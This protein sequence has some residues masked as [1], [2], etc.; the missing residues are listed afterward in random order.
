M[1]E[2]KPWQPSKNIIIPDEIEKNILKNVNENILVV[3]GPGSGKTEMLAQK[4]NFLFETDLCKNPYKILALSYKV[5]AA[6]TLKDRVKKRCGDIANYRFDSYT[7]DAFLF[8]IVQRF[9]KL[10]PDWIEPLSSNMVMCSD[11]KNLKQDIISSDTDQ[12]ARINRYIKKKLMP[13]NLMRNMGYTIILHNQEVREIVSSP[14]QYIFIDEFQDTT[15]MHYNILELLFNKNNIRFMAVGDSKQSIMGFAG[16]L[17][18]IFEKYL[19]DYNAKEYP[20][21]YNYRSNSN[22]VY[23]MNEVIENLL[24]QYKKNKMIAYKKSDDKYS[25][26]QNGQ[27]E[28]Y[29][30]QF[31]SIANYISNKIQSNN[32]KQHDFV[33]VKRTRMLQDNINKINDIFTRYGLLIRNDMEKIYKDITIQNLLEYQLSRFLIHFFAY[34]EGSITPENYQELLSTYSTYKNYDISES[35]NYDKATKNIIVLRKNVLEIANI[36]KRVKLIVEHFNINTII[37]I[38]RDIKSHEKFQDIIKAFSEYFSFLFSNSN[39]QLEAISKFYGE[40]Q[41]KIMTIH[42]SKGMEY[43]TVIFLDFN[44]IEWDIF[45]TG[46]DEEEFSEL[47]VFFVGISRAKNTLIFT[48]NKHNSFPSKT[49]D[50]IQKLPIFE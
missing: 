45:K 18:S 44:S 39:S 9:Y 30:I 3:A 37:S 13:W 46:S 47:K 19:H 36:T 50:I 25:V 32:L 6:R 40:N 5:D 31:K 41:I 33:I 17:N 7:L 26:F 1:K 48:K 12:Q 49:E 22:I 29:E 27:Y 24:P 4:V 21:N 38:D 16:A 28:N 35:A 23:F 20:L 42:K 2:I 15:E 10:L 14:Y 34:L 11:D 43:D 8:S